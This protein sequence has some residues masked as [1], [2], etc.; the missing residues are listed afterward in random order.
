MLLEV[1][2]QHQKAAQGNSTA[3]QRFL[4]AQVLWDETMAEKIAEFVNAHPDYQVVVLAGQG[5]IVYGYGIPGRVERRL[6][7]GKVKMRSVLFNFPTDSPFSA[8]KPI[9]DYVWRH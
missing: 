2:Q 3:F 6:G 7:V 1:Y 8:D 9:A 5:H 4:Q